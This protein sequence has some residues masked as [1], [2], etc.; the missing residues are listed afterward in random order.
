MIPFF[1]NTRDELVT[2]DEKGVFF[3]IGRR[4][5]LNNKYITCV[6]IL[7][8]QLILSDLDALN[9]FCKDFPTDL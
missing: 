1:F 9:L 2:K 7:K 3:R 8:Q 5:I 6:N 4:Y